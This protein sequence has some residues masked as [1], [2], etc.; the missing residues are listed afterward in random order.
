MATV[1]ILYIPHI[2]EWNHSSCPGTSDH[3]SCWEKESEYI[4]TNKFPF[5][6]TYA[7]LDHWWATLITT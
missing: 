7:S 5:S 6:I 2:D 1:N 4:H 3:K